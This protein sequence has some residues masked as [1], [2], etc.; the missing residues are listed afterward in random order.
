LGQEFT[1]KS[2]AI[3]DKI[4]QL[5]PSQGGFGAGV[6]FSAS[7]MVVPIIDLTETAEGSGVRQ[8]LQTA[9]SHNSATVFS[10]TNATTTVVNTTGYW[11]ITGAAGVNNDATS[12]G[13]CNII[14]ND[15]TTD[16]IVWGLKNTVALTNNLPS[17]NVDYLVYLIAGDSLIIEST[18]T[19]SHFVGSVRQIADI[20]GN[21]VNP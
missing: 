1:I 6:D 3:E 13:E 20:N 19:E 4:N 18:N 2:D 11:R 8:D 12:G 10:V 9:L 21:L 7:T 14:I 16:K 5:L 17:L 15:G